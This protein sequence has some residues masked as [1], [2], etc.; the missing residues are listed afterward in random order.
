MDG[1]LFLINSDGPHHFAVAHYIA[2]RI[3]EPVPL[4][5]QLYRHGINAQ[6]IQ[7]LRSEFDIFAIGEAK[8]FNQ[9]FN[10]AMRI[11]KADYY[12]V[13]PARP[14]AEQQAVS[15]PRDRVRSDKVAETLRAKGFF[16][17]VQYQQ[18]LRFEGSTARI[19]K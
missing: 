12:Y 15:L 8:G 10:E 16:N 19:I 2:Q 9:E 4:Q 6:A 1:L 18:D 11:Y 7:K 17:L 5:R 3:A 14:Y 13:N